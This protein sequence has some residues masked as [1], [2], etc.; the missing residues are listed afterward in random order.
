MG[1]AEPT[2]ADSVIERCREALAV[3]EAGPFA[4]YVPY[5][6]HTGRIL[7]SLAG[8]QPRALATQHGSTYYGDG[9]QALRDLAGVMREVL[10]PRGADR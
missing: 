2:T 1:P 4:N 3:A 7:E 5:T 9:G 6:H 10:G 8:H